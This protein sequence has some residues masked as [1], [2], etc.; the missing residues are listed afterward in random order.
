M[1]QMTE[2][3]DR[4]A[5]KADIELSLEAMEANNDR[6]PYQELVEILRGHG[7]PPRQ[8]RWRYWRDFDD[9]RR[10]WGEC[11]RRRNRSIEDAIRAGMRDCDIIV[12]M[13][14]DAKQVTEAKRRM[15][16]PLRPVRRWQEYHG[17]I[18]AMLSKGHTSYEIAEFLGSKVLTMTQGCNRTGLPFPQRQSA[19]AKAALAVLRAKNG[20]PP[21]EPI[22]K[23]PGPKPKAKKTHEER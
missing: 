3:Y 12:K 19:A 9:L 2:A 23:K 14:A 16:I 8:W 11:Q 17:I 13:G 18:K 22:R 15:G 1:R 4:E 10:R 20:L 21:W 7:I 6:S 5:V